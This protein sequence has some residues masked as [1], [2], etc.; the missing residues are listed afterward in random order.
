L[1]NIKGI[2]EGK[3]D[4]IYEAAQK[5]AQC[6]FQTGLIFK[7]KREKILRITTGSGVLDKLIAGGIESCAITEV[8]GEFRTGKT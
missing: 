3:L 4:K 1:L 8:F 5:I 7:Q 2:S 6:G